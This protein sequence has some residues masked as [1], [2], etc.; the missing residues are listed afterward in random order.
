MT[1]HAT[2][3]ISDG[4]IIG[5]NCSVGPYT[6]IGPKVVLG[7]DNWVGP[8]VVIEGNTHIGSG[9]KIFQFASI[10]AAP[11]DLKY[12]GEDSLLRIGNNNLIRE[13]VTLQPGT[14][15]GGMQTIIGNSNL[16]MACSHVGHDSKIGNSNVIANAA[17][18][19]GHVSIGDFATIG[20][21]CGIHQFVSIGDYAL[22][23]AGAMVSQD[24]PPFL[25]G[26]GDRAHL[27]GVNVVALQRRGFSAEDIQSLKRV[28]RE[29]F[30]SDGIFKER[31]ARA[32][33]K[34]VDFPHAQTLLNFIENSERGVAS[35]RRGA[36]QEESE[37]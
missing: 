27:T 26:Q 15:G 5:D 12:R 35:A 7:S 8:H 33:S 2:A 29:V 22:L 16:F 31:A 17:A 11:Q 1:I 34:F 9:N 19:A 4:A 6:V 18:I 10:G 37:D 24:I 30:L 28:Y 21:L 3:I 13:Y 25:V 32:R 36:K 14:T 23:G 20:G